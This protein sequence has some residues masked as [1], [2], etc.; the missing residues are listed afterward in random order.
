MASWLVSFLRFEVTGYF[1]Y[2]H[3]NVLQLGVFHVVNKCRNERSHP[4]IREI[5]N[6]CLIA[7]HK[8][9]VCQFDN[10]IYIDN[11]T[12]IVTSNGGTLL[13]SLKFSG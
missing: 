2:V 3:G 4:L 6:T 9:Q 8:L 10:L 12:H 5:F 7:F 1:N 11:Y 13:Y